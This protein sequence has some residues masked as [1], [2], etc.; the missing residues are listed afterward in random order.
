MA[1]TVLAPNGVVADEALLDAGDDGA[2][3]EVDHDSEGDFG[4]G[5]EFFRSVEEGFRIQFVD[6][7]E[8]GCGEHDAE[9]VGEKG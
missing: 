2:G 5:L 6:T 8:G 3:D 9:E 7:A 1:P 4:G